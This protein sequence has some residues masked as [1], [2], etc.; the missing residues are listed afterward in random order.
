VNSLQQAEEII[1]SQQHIETERN[2][3]YLKAEWGDNRTAQSL[4]A[5]WKMIQ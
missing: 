5:L 4:I 3:T 2:V 1:R